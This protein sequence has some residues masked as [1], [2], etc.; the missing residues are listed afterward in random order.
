MTQL[1]TDNVWT[2]PCIIYDAL[3]LYIIYALTGRCD[4]SSCLYTGRKEIYS[5]NVSDAGQN[6]QFSFCALIHFKIHTKNTF[7]FT[8]KV[9]FCA[10]IDSVFI[11]IV[12]QSGTLILKKL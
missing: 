8:L 7:F 11:G 6:S 2:E 4:C 9:P 12:T 5:F 1:N 3:I 10:F